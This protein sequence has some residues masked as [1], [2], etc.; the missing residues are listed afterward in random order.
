MKCNRVGLNLILLW[1]DMYRG[2]YCTVSG[3]NNE[4]L[5]CE[6]P[7]EDDGDKN[8]VKALVTILGENNM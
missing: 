3:V 1:C 6:G 5:R 7:A 4:D 8:S 2:M